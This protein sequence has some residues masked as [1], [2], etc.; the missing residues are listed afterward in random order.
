MRAGKSLISVHKFLKFFLA[1]IA[2]VFIDRH[3]LLLEQQ[4]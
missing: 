2:L 3:V 4:Q 1:G